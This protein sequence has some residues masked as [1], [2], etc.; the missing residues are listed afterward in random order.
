MSDRLA[1]VPDPEAWSPSRA[2]LRHQREAAHQIL[3]S[4]DEGSYVTLLGPHFSGKTLLVQAVAEMLAQRTYPPCVYVDLSRLAASTVRGFFGDLTRVTTQRLT[5]TTHLA[6]AREPAGATSADYRS[7]LV[8]AV[9]QLDDDLVLLLDHL[10]SLPTDLAQALLTSLRAAYMEQSTLHCRL[11][12]VASGALSF[13]GLT[14]GESSPFRGIARRVYIRDLSEQESEALIAEQIEAEQVPTTD[15]ARHRLL[16]AAR[17]DPTLIR[18]LTRD[19]IRA[20]QAT[21]SGRLTVRTVEQVLRHFLDDEVAI[22]AP[23][24]EAVRQ[25]ED[26]PELLRCVLLLLEHGTLPRA[27]LPLPLSP[28]VDPLY[29]TGVVERLD[30]D[31][32][33]LRNDICRRF[34]ARRLDPGR[35]GHLLTMAGEWDSAIDYL[36]S[37]IGPESQANRSDL[38]LATI[39]SMYASEDVGQAAHFLLRGLVASFGIQE[40]QVWVGLAHE[41]SLRLLE[42][43]S[44]GTGPHAP[45]AQ[46]AVSLETIGVQEDRLEAR[47]YREASPMRETEG[48]SGLRRAIPLLVPGQRPLG[49]VCLTDSGGDRFTE[50]RE[51]DLLLLGYLNQAARAFQQV[52]RRTRELALAGRVQAMMLPHVPTLAGWQLAAVLMPARQT[53]GDFYDLIPLRDGRLGIAIADVADKGMGAALYMA[54]SRT[55]IRTHATLN[56]GD[57]VRVLG[58]ANRGMLRDAPAGLFVTAFYG[59]L[60]PVAGE[61]VY[62]NAGHPPPIVLRSGTSAVEELT[63]TGMALGASPDEAW[64]AERLRL[65]PGDLLVCYTDGLPDAKNSQQDFFGRQRALEVLRSQARRTA[66]EVQEA[67]LEAVNGFVGPEPQFDDLTLVL[68]KREEAGKPPEA[69]PRP[70]PEYPTFRARV[71]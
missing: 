54:L 17:G 12:V 28:D 24:Q 69:R 1:P 26:D 35:V 34:L 15:R 59:V 48:G 62:C 63:R 10:E 47:A 16:H 23:L 22:Y 55:L 38:L 58:E 42:Q 9:A 2:L 53:A 50:Q 21:A 60:D 71:I 61:L 33:R 67:L 57:P 27:E 39:H 5:E 44:R 52:S 11:L 40:A 13:A 30:G 68:L 19:A 46:H 70:L 43:I 31:R 29:L 3:E 41:P 65:A 8:G 66:P 18:H 25:I 51:R 20:A 64:R 36:E 6:F 56:P 32:Y 4:I 7:F 49:V 37:S 14:L 45:G